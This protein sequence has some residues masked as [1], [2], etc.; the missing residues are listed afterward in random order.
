M[1]PR[2]MA[3]PPPAGTVF[4]EKEKKARKAPH[5]DPF[6]N[7]VRAVLVQIHP[8]ARITRQAKEVVLSI[9]TDFENRLAQQASDLARRDKR[10]TVQ[11]RDVA[12]ATQTN[13]PAELAKHAVSEG[14]KAATKNKSTHSNAT[15]GLV[16]RPSRLHKQMKAERNGAR[17]SPQAAAYLAGVLEYLVA[18]L[19][20]GAGNNAVGRGAV[21]IK[22]QDLHAAIQG[23]A[24]LKEVFGKAMFGGTGAVANINEALLPPGHKKKKK[25]SKK[26]KKSTKKK[27]SKGKKKST[28]KKK[29]PAPCP[30]RSRKRTG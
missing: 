19:L 23:D 28:K 2:R 15:S 29:S 25:S 12:A 16:F 11:A 24:E 27:K 17:V 13:L 7:F 20:E 30:R 14:T 5:Y 8:G 6:R 18:E 9:V 22:R 21:T 4:I 26:K 10:A 3:G 1:P